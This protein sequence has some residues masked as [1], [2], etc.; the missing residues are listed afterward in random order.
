MNIDCLATCNLWRMW[1]HPA[2]QYNCSRVY[3]STLQRNPV[4]DWNCAKSCS[5][6]SASFHQSSF[7]LQM[8]AYKEG[9]V[10][11]STAL[12]PVLCFLMGRR[13]MELCLALPHQWGHRVTKDS[14]LGSWA[15]Q[16]ALSAPKATGDGSQ[17]QGSLPCLSA[18]P[19][20]ILWHISSPTC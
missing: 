7:L 13:R 9:R 20:R 1:K 8:S 3:G 10:I 11:L 16:P 19:P 15:L 17:Q 5:H 6:L 4:R 14:E 12:L 2:N 18:S